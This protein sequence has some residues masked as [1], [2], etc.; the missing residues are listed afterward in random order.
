MSIENPPDISTRIVSGLIESSTESDT[1]FTELVLHPVDARGEWP[2]EIV[3]IQNPKGK[4][5]CNFYPGGITPKAT[6]SES[7]KLEALL[8]MIATSFAD[9]N[10]ST[11]GEELKKIR[12]KI[13]HDSNVT[14]PY[15][16]W[17]KYLSDPRFSVTP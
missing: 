3:R 11:V 15:S 6:Y 4:P 10:N 7:E 12:E 2:L 9:T 5:I 8:Q 1:A 17:E 14:F 16:V 13:K